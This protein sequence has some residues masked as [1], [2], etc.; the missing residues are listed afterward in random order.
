LKSTSGILLDE[1]ADEE[2]LLAICS[3]LEQEANCKVVDLHVWVVAPGIRSAIVSIVATAPQQPIYYKQ[4][5]PSDLRLEHLS[6]EVHKL[7]K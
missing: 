4:L 3:S 2:T 5:L 7:T 6:I 1:Q